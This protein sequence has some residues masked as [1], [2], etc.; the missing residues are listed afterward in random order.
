M[1][2]CTPPP[3]RPLLLSDISLPPPIA[4][5]LHDLSS[6]KAKRDFYNFLFQETPIPHG[7][8]A[9]PNHDSPLFTPSKFNMLMR[10]G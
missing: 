4:I 5:R 6:A 3:P 7:E 9:L 8:P 10:L 1:E 2:L